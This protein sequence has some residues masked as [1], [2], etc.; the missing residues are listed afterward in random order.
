MATMIAVM[1]GTTGVPVTIKLMFLFVC[2]KIAG[3]MDIKVV[4][5]QRVDL[6]HH[7]L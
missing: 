5:F 2:K 6:L 1:A 4:L 7:L 3:R